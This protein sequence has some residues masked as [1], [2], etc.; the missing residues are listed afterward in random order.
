[1]PCPSHAAP[2]SHWATPGCRDCPRHL[3]PSFRPDDRFREAGYWHL[4]TSLCSTLWFP[5]GTPPVL[6]VW[7]ATQIGSMDLWVYLL[8]RLRQVF[9]RGRGMALWIRALAI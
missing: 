8:A 6:G 3:L 7:A 1:M 5:G 9:A 4:A 2:S